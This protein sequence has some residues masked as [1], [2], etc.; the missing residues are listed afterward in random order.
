MTNSELN[1]QISDYKSELENIRDWVLLNGRTATDSQLF[2]KLSQA[3]KIRKEIQILI[4]K[5]RTL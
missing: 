1:Q 5:K 4:N 3:S 2:T